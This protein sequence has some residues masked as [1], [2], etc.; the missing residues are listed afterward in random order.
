MDCYNL[1]I[2]FLRFPFAMMEVSIQT[3]RKTRRKFKSA[4]CMF[5]FAQYGVLKAIYHTQ[6][7]KLYALRNMALKFKLKPCFGLLW[8]KKVLI[9]C[10]LLF[11]KSEWKSA[12]YIDTVRKDW[13]WSL[14]EQWGLC[15]HVVSQTWTV[16]ALKNPV[17]FFGSL[18]DVSTHDNSNILGKSNKVRVIGSSKQIP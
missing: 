2:A 6:L 12:L 7:S 8:I 5:I 17:N 9:I 1:K 13:C 18:D 10:D 4:S 11:T 15:R 16:L 14:L 3:W